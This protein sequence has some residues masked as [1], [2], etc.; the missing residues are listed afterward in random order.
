MNLMLTHIHRHMRRLALYGATALFMGIMASAC[1][2]D[3]IDCQTE[4]PGTANESASYY[5]AIQ[6]FDTADAAG[7]GTRGAFDSDFNDKDGDDGNI[8]NKGLNGE[9]AI[10]ADYSNGM[11]NFIMLFNQN[12]EKI[13]DLI[14]LKPLLPED[15]QDPEKEQDPDED[16]GPSVDTPFYS[17]YSL[18][19][20]TLSEDDVI[21]DQFGDNGEL[22]SSIS[23]V[24]VVLNASQAIRTKLNG[25]TNYSD[26]MDIKMSETDA[27]ADTPT[28]FLYLDAGSTRYFTMSSSMVIK[29]DENGKYVDA[30][31]IC[32][33]KTDTKDEE[34][35][36]HPTNCKLKDHL[37]KTKAEALRKPFCM[38]VERAQSKYTVL[39]KKKGDDN[40]YYLDK[41][42]AQQVYTQFPVNSLT[43]EYSKVNSEDNN[44]FN[45]KE[46]Y[47]S[48]NYVKDYTRSTSVDNRNDVTVSTANGW[49]VNITGWGVNGLEKNEYLFKQIKSD[50]DY[51]TGWQSSA[52][53]YRNFWAE[54]LNYN[55]GNYPDQYR[56]SLNLTNEGLKK[57]TETAEWT[58]DATLNYFSFDKLNQKAPHQYSPENTFNT[59]A[60]GKTD[61]DLTEAFESKAYLRT[62]THI[63]V[64]AQLLLQ[65]FDLDDAYAA[66]KNIDA[67]SGLVKT[68]AD[69]LYMNG[70]YWSENAYKNYVAEYL[71]YWMLT[72]EN[73]KIFGPNDGN[74]YVTD[75][76][77]YR[78]ADYRD[79]E[80]KPAKIKGGDGWVYLFPT[81]ELYTRTPGANPTYTSIFSTEKDTEKYEVLA[82][83][84]QDLMAGHFKNGRMYYAVPIKHN[85]PT[86]GPKNPISTGDFGAVRNHWYAFTVTTIN[87]VGTPVD[88]PEQPIIPNVEPKTPGLGVEIRILDWHKISTE[89]DVS[90]QRPNK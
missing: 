75:N 23:K 11:P 9:K 89:V 31:T 57:D 37:Y 35:V 66:E 51:Y 6:I 74:F 60:F 44:D 20:A 70:I 5:M 42:D 48:L 69:K 55:S 67:E 53:A 87:S 78:L 72:E 52:Y 61:T 24:L 12:D 7:N 38:Y 16:G 73:Q 63:I 39:F 2:T 33:V 86:S 8:Y 22:I 21:R 71:A 34:T 49:K 10:Y 45:P 14:H 36:E 30:A 28:D 27:A 4:E 19:L 90:G 29:T 26:I 18:F 54:D 62:G 50:V 3:A 84:H 82:Y 85:N 77:N 83:E 32:N 68:A 1:S 13:G 56:E 64:N 46:E 65:G 80:L 40:E 79:F 25:L 81:K 59:E 88:D 41:A 43:Y 47:K 17:T 15:T 76:G 58:S